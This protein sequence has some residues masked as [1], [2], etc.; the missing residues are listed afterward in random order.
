MKVGYWIQNAD[1]SAVDHDPVDY[2]GALAAW[3]GHDWAAALAEFDKLDSAGEDCCPPGIGFTRPMTP[4]AEFLQICPAPDSSWT[5]YYQ[6][7]ARND[8]ASLGA[9]NATDGTV[10]T[11]LH[12]FFADDRAGVEAALERYNK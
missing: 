10:E 3:R 2:Q 8:A 11:A 4:I 7:P 9:D 12:A 1:Y 5:I 6:H